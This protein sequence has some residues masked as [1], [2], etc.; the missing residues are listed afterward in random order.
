MRGIIKARL[1]AGLRVHT[2]FVMFAHRYRSF[3]TRLCLLLGVC[4][5]TLGA[6]PPTTSQAAIAK[7]TVDD[8][9]SDFSRGSFQRTVL[10][11][12]Q[13]TN[14]SPT[15][16]SGAVQL[17]PIGLL[18]NWIDSPFVLKKSLMRMGATAIG[19]RLF[20]IGG[21]TPVNNAPQ[22]VADVWSA[23]VSQTTGALNED[24]QP[25]PSLPAVQGSNQP[26]FTTP[27]APVNS[28]GVTSVANGSGGGY[29]YVIGGNAQPTTS[30]T[31]DFSSYAVRIGVVGNDGRVTSW[32][33]GPA[34]PSP[35]PNDPFL[36]LGIQSP[37]VTN[38]TVNGKTYVYVIG[39][40]KRYR[41][42]T[43]FQARTVGEGSKDVFVARVG[44][45]GQLVKPSS[46]AAGWDKINSIPV[47]G[48]S[49]AGLWDAAIMSDHFI[50]STGETAD[51][52]YVVGGQLTPNDPAGNPP[53]LPSF[54]STVY[55]A[56][57]NANGT[58]T[59]DFTWQG[60]L[61][62]TRTGF[63]GVTFHSSLYAV[64]GLP[65]N[66]D[67][68]DKGVLTSYVEDDM[69][70]HQFNALEVPPGI[71]GGGSN[72]LK[73]DSLP[74]ARAFHATAIVP[75]DATSANSA[76][77]YV[78]GGRGDTSD[79]NTS[80]DYGTNGVIFGKIGGSEDVNST[81]YAS[82]GWFYSKPYD[83]NFAGAQ[84][85]KIYWSTQLVRQGANPDI[86]MEYRI[87]SGN[88]CATADW[89]DSSWVALKATESD[90]SHTSANGSNTSPAINLSARCFQYRAK[91]VTDNYLVTPSLLN[92]SI[93]IVIPGN[94]DLKFK[95]ISPILSGS[96]LSGINVVIQNQNTFEQTLP[97]DTEARGSF[98]VDMCIFA[99]GETVVVPTIPLTNQNMQC[100]D[101]YANVNRSI[102]VVDKVYGITRWLA[103][104]G[105][106]HDQPVN[107]LSFFKT[108]GTYTIILLADSYN[109]VAEGTEGEKNN[110]SQPISFNVGKIGY[111]INIPMTR[112]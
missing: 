69:K 18:K 17:G 72:F 40:L 77:V 102:M 49:P 61:P 1:S 24:W 46:G 53:S 91:L 108:P 35:D 109:N 47:P 58:L 106:N 21:L 95:T 7:S 33:A 11:P 74:S 14:L 87:S 52:I 55:R 68:P 56:F 70:L 2:R 81:G 103:S 64:G 60:T 6:L 88:S 111:A 85:Q 23:S 4:L 44:T 39:G 110:I 112:K 67:K 97:A 3:R 94:P 45:G 31:F 62:Q 86:N 92:V 43:G 38:L 26:G 30:S 32:I 15:D 28:P 105:T 104:T 16:K 96:T 78:F 80:D 75:A 93:D 73:S 79:A 10:G 29:I 99:P 5:L 25:E 84:L 63:N 71:D 19:N 107:I 20:I 8:T 90:A 101:A 12:L 34:L 37:A 89:T 83:V 59:W 98:F 50:V 27:V 51:I 36:Q 48:S 57:V 42:G 9:I 54:N 22:S 65:N 100:S 76:F 41:V 66:G 82:S 13:N